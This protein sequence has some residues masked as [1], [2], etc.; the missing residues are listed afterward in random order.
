MK[1]LILDPS[2]FGSAR[3]TT[4]DRS[5]NRLGNGETALGRQVRIL[6]ALGITDF[7]VASARC[8]QDLNEVR[9]SPQF[10]GLRFVQP[11]QDAE[12]AAMLNWLWQHLDDAAFVVHSDAVFDAD[13]VSR[14]LLDSHQDLIA[15]AQEPA[16]KPTPETLARDVYPVEFAGTKG[17]ASLEGF[18]CKL[19]ARTLRLW[20]AR[21]AALADQDAGQDRV[22]AVRGA[23][24]RDL[25]IASF[26]TVGHLLGAARTPTR[27]AQISAD[28]RLYDL[29]QQPIVAEPYGY[30]RLAAILK[31]FGIRKPLLICD[32][33][34]DGSPV[35]EHLKALDLDLVRFDVLGERASYAQA[36]DG[37]RTFS[38]KGC[39]GVLTI[40]GD[41]A[42]ATGKCV[43]LFSALDPGRDYLEQGKRYSPIKH[44]VL[45]VG[46]GEGGESTPFSW[47]DVDG[48]LRLVDHDAMLPDQVL[49][50]P[51]LNARVSAYQRKSA[52]LATFS[53][54]IEAAW[55]LSA[56]EE[57]Q[58]EA[59]SGIDLLMKS[60][61]T[62]LRTDEPTA[63]L[64]MMRAANLAGR[65]I[66]IS[67]NTALQAMGG[68]LA[69]R[70]GIPQ[71]LAEMMCLRA[72]W[73]HWTRR[74][75]IGP[76]VP[77]DARFRQVTDRLCR[78]LGVT[79]VRDAITLIDRLL[80]FLDLD[81]PA[82][83]R[84]TDLDELITG[85]NQECLA[86]SPLSLDPRE[87]R[88]V[89]AEVLNHQQQRLE[90][91]TATREFGIL[92]RFAEFCQRQR[93]QYY[94]AGETLR[95]AVVHGRVTPWNPMLSVAMPRDAYAKLLQLR[96]QLPVGLLL[97]DT[98]A[99]FGRVP[100]RARIVD[101]ADIGDQDYQ[102]GAS[103]RQGPR[104]ELRVLDV[105]DGGAVSRGIHRASLRAIHGA[106]Q[107][108]EGQSN[109]AQGGILNRGLDLVRRRLDPGA[110]AKAH[111]LANRIHPSG[112]VAQSYVDIG[113]HAQF[114]RSQ[115]PAKWFRS[116]SEA[117]L[118]GIPFRVPEHARGVLARTYGMSYRS[119]K[120]VPLEMRLRAMPTQSQ[121]DRLFRRAGLEPSAQVDRTTGSPFISIVVPVYNVEEFLPEC[122]DSLCM[123]DYQGYEII[124]VNDGSPDNSQAILE[125]Y[126][127]R[128]PDRF[129]VF[130]K[131]NGGLSDARN[132]GIE[133][134]RGEYVAFVDSDDIVSPRMVRLMAEKA[135]ST[136]ADL[137]VCRM[138]E[139][140]AE[141]NRCE[142]GRMRSVGS[143]GHSVRERPEL[144]IAAQPY[145][146]NKIYRRRLF[147]DYGITYPKGQAFED[148]A[149][150]FN[151]MLEA[152]RIELVDEVLY[153][154]RKDRPDSI[155][156]TFDSRFFDIFKS[157]D[158]I[159]RYYASRELDTLF[160]S[161][162][163]E[164]MRRT[165][166]ARINA[167][168]SCSD[169]EGIYAFI[170]A[171]YDY[172]ETNAP[173]WTDNPYFQGQL[174]NPAYGEHPKYRAAASRQAMKAYFA[175]LWR[176]QD[177]GAG[178]SPGYSTEELTAMLQR[179][180]L[181]ILLRIDEFCDRQGLTYY[182]AEG[183]LLGAIRHQGFIPWDDDIDICMPRADYERF[184]QLMLESRAPG[185]RLF[186][187]RTFPRYHLTFTK[188]LAA[189]PSGFTT[190]FVDV[191][192]KFKG[193]AVDIFPLDAEVKARDLPRERRVRWLRD[194][195]LF[196]VGYMSQ[197]T[198]RKKPD[199]YLASKG[200][201][202]GW[203]QRSTQELY[204]V[205]EGDPEADY[206][207]NYASSYSVSKE[208]FRG[209]WFG[210][211]RR[212]PF[213]GHLLPVPSNWDAVLSTTYGS[214]MELPPAKRR[215]LRHRPKWQGGLIDG[216]TVGE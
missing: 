179:E 76:D 6:A 74:V 65:A 134:A 138:A 107:H 135:R 207:V 55:G 90:G 128:Y 150:T 209:T 208:K 105:V 157:F 197:A 202:F 22:E 35:A 176:K 175:E 120:A 98:A 109:D 70:Y 177:E 82:P 210:T 72:L 18:I 119:V 113:A 215:V 60:L 194:V 161:E 214:Y 47:L 97:D 115:Y 106:S 182:L 27:L 203:L 38:A 129:R 186:N 100:G 62:Y 68:Q 193:P 104:L 130:V 155:T 173:D 180:T 144:L 131:E 58:G 29:R 160:R 133:R 122:L 80:A 73:R 34:Y 7:V 12:E 92:V 26:A 56:T 5:T 140:W 71:G 23:V 191:P 190:V 200:Y 99:V 36:A 39:D 117:I 114:A 123:Q 75:G 59:L 78:R 199:R 69:R 25:G 51:T 152:N 49:L 81:G 171:I 95:D 158:S 28:V 44:V 154:Y 20:L 40:G 10:I 206:L 87:L 112:S 83:H 149:T 148:S 13:L 126:A 101:R 143:F 8:T 146:W 33:G 43:K 162:I 85:I 118:N 94:L 21:L 196:K 145:A 168:E 132:Y 2:A 137:V 96:D 170:D 178:N 88:R 204:R 185:L 111:A 41:A 32:D 24:A 45:P 9:S 212:V 139:Y 66:S 37:A 48:A 42:I 121:I 141:S 172:M 19:S 11:G 166:F 102:A 184:I 142:A 188:V 164:L 53:R 205:H 136:D 14:M 17:G 187:E 91:D 125:A 108:T 77:R 156:N 124:A 61:F 103:L 174:K 211:P 50:E 127:L 46:A 192:D 198:R 165:I 57:S 213:E 52:A 67:R 64:S 216:V 86:N 110:L 15:Y 116:G 4:S 169:R 163:N 31:E 183:T 16:F 181:S 167:L 189:E 159:R 1:A 54:C 3:G 79:R 153:L 147:T 151:L 89:Y 201:S 84:P 195:L 63:Q 30:V 93:V